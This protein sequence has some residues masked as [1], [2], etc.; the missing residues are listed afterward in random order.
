MPNPNPKNPTPSIEAKGG[1]EVHVNEWCE[2]HG[3]DV[4][5]KDLVDL[6]ESR[7]QPKIPNIMRIFG[8]ETWSTASKWKVRY[9]KEKSNG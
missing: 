6:M 4:S 2:K 1:L 8:I 5:Y 9:E 7:V 3:L